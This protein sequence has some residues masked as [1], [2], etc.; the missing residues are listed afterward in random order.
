MIF[1]KQLLPSVLNR[2]QSTELGPIGI[3][4]AQEKM[5]LL[6]LEKKK[7][8]IR[9]RANASVPYPV[10]RAELLT[11][12]AEFSLFIHKILKTRPFK[13][14]DIVSCLPNKGTKIINLSYQMQTGMS[15]D[16]AVVNGVMN[17]LDG[18]QS[19]YV[20]DYLPI[21]TENKNSATRTALVAVAKR[22]AVTSYLELFA[23]ANL[24][25]DALDIGPAALR[26]L[27]AASDS[28]DEFPLVLLMNFGREKSYLTVID[29]RRLIMDRELDFGENRLIHQLSKL[30]DLREDQALRIL[31]QYGLWKSDPGADQNLQDKAQ[32][33]LS[34]V[35]E[36]LHPVF[37]EFIDNVNKT[38]IYTAS[39][40]HGKSVQQIY[41]LGSVA[42]YP[43]ADTFLEQMLSL[44]VSVMEPFSLF[45][46]S[47]SDGKP[48]SPDI[49]AGDALATG[50]AL[51]GF[52]N[53]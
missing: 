15:E 47:N 12:T 42:R 35:A 43:G 19:E 45:E 48:L 39:M 10:S 14:N 6:Q 27:V 22:E 28:S 13:G 49:K 3:N 29:G 17:C 9:I 41:L 26:R 23:R 31:T 5:H 25:V 50:L 32:E 46:T 7:D 1:S 36:I 21:R 8:T 33:I 24:S 37:L 44:P 18:N 11:S 52:S 20:I 40:L 2:I 38:L 4:I 51:R 53:G 16:E 34:S 30:L